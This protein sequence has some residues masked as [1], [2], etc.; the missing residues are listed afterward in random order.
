MKNQKT[1]TKVLAGVVIAG[2][3]LSVGGQALAYSRLSSSTNPKSLN[4]QKIHKEGKF[5][6]QFPA[7]GIKTQLDS[8]VKSG[9][10]TEEQKGKII[11]FIEQKNEE[12]K[13]EMEK[14]KVMSEED[15]KAYFETNKIKVRQDMFSE[16]VAQNII[17]QNQAD[18]IKKAM[19]QKQVRVKIDF[20]KGI[21]TQLD[22]QVK[23]GVITQT[24][25]DKISSYL[26][27]KA[28]ARK[29]EM[30][31]VKAMSDEERKAYFEANMNTQRSD[32]FTELVKEN[33][34]SQDK[35]DALKKA[36]PAHEKGDKVK[37]KAN[38]N[39]KRN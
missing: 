4:V 37:F 3:T 27:K 21:T 26:E 25:K 36:M 2:V 1:M 7:E 23:A 12:H 18:A 5:K 20:G 39:F 14:I 8:L 28:E 6:D 10:I 30:E 38:K 17:D 22:D 19:P 13:S 11:A 15:R 34:L 33:I 35:A 9:T 24:E 31:K 16:L 32:L 29:A